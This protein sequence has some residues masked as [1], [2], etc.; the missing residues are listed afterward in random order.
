[1][2]TFRLDEYQKNIQWKSPEK[3][4]KISGRNIA[5]TKSLELR[6][7]GGFRAGLP[8]LGDANN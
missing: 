8:D 7:T 6:G 1:L 4:R 3:I 2:I 5:S